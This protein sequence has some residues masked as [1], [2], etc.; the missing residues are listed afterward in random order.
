M[1]E[2]PLFDQQV[3]FLYTRD[4]KASAAF[5]GE[6]LGLPLAL[7]QGAC[8]IFRVSP[9]SFI[10]ICECNP[11]R[12]SNPD[13]IIVTLV[14]SDVDGWYNRLNAKGV[15]FDG[16]PSENPKFNIYHCFLRDPDGYQI[17]IQHFRDEN[18][19]KPTGSD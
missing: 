4:L 5:Y 19:P 16:P 6:T 3:T 12:P 7:D 11:E 10:G 1:S 8:Q 2:A 18:W 17:E 14:S 13:G 9:D 15:T